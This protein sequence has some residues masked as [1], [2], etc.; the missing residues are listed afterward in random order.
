MVLGGDTQHA[1]GSARHAG[2]TWDEDNLAENER[3]K[4]ELNPQKINEP[5]TPWQELLPDDD[6]DLP[7]L[8]LDGGGTCREK[9]P[10]GGSSGMGVGCSGTARS[11]G[12]GYVTSP[13]LLLATCHA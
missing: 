5:K 9:T 4:A 7:A 3:I 6:I 2:I 10:Q 1:V 11:Q 8:D 12:M 13:H